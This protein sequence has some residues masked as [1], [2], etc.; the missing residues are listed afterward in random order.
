MLVPGPLARVSIALAASTCKAPTT[1][2]AWLAC[3]VANLS[4]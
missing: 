1:T 2:D 3:D 4:G